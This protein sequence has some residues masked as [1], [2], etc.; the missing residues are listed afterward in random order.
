M[1][2]DT[3]DGKTY[4]C[5]HTEDNSICKKCLGIS[6]PSIEK[7]EPKYCNICKTFGICRDTQHKEISEKISVDKEE[8]WI[9]SLEEELPIPSNPKL[10]ILIKHFISKVATQSKLQERER[11]VKEIEKK[12]P[13]Y[14]E[15][16]HDEVE[17][18]INLI[19]KAQ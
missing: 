11:I 3:P 4:S 14:T 1:F 7:E 12:Y 9:K 5:S 16:Y 13:N 19:N 6:T 10:A 2:K 18:I 15:D 8:W 17:E